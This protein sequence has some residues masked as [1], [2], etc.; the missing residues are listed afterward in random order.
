MINRKS[1][2]PN[3]QTTS[4]GI[5]TNSDVIVSESFDGGSTWSAPIS[6]SSTVDGD[7]FMP[8]G[9]FDATGRLRV[10]YF[11][12]SYDAANHLYGYSL[13]T[14]TA[15]ALTATVPTNTYSRVKVTTVL[16][17]PTKN[18]RWFATTLDP[19]FPFATQFLGDY[20]NIAVIPGTTS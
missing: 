11:D 6:L 2:F 15:A 18:D 12:R 8:W 14:E 4:Y 3:Y 5:S 7:Q 13:A 9:A 17:D 16:S 10:G 1:V 19:A 20:S